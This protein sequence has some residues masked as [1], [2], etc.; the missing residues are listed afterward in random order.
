MPAHEESV[1]MRTSQVLGAPA[2]LMTRSCRG[3]NVSTR[4]KSTTLRRWKHSLAE[5]ISNELK[6]WSFTTPKILRIPL[7]SNENSLLGILKSANKN[8][9]STKLQPLRRIVKRS[10]EWKEKKDSKTRPSL[11]ARRPEKTNQTPGIEQ[12]TRETPNSTQI[13][14]P[15]QLQKL[16]QDPTSQSPWSRAIRALIGGRRRRG[17][18]DSAQRRKQGRMRRGCGRSRSGETGAMTRDQEERRTRR[19][20]LGEGRTGGVASHFLSLSLSC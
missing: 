10:T 6:W 7:N 17:G 11:L 1:G 8:K 4:N 12:D 9:P 15:N 18:G 14:R 3:K 13:R 16:N 19:Q 2:K 5:P 20:G